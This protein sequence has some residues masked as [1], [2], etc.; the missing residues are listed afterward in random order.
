MMIFNTINLIFGLIVVV[1]EVMK[2]ALGPAAPASSMVQVSKGEDG[3]TRRQ[4][5]RRGIRAGANRCWF[6]CS[7]LSLV[8]LQLEGLLVLELSAEAFTLGGVLVSAY[9][10]LLLNQRKPG[11]CRTQSLRYQELQEVLRAGGKYGAATYELIFFQWLF[12]P[13]ALKGKQW[14]REERKGS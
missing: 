14:D 9:S 10:L 6:P 3:K 1:V 4:K 7:I 12:W 13:V 11:C 5:D 2:T 8:C